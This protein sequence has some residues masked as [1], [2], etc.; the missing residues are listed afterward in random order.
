MSELGSAGVDGCGDSDA[1]VGAAWFERFELALGRDACSF[2]SRDGLARVVGAAA[3]AA[4]GEAAG[5]AG[6]AGAE[7]GDGDGGVGAATGAFGGTAGAGAGG[8]VRGGDE[9]APPARGWVSAFRAPAAD[10]TA[11]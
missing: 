4:A 6:A 10:G 8:R 7:G 1:C 2:F 5:A 11:A 9:G 3:G